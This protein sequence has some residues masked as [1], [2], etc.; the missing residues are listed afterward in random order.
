VIDGSIRSSDLLVRFGGDEFLVTTLETDLKECE[1]LISRINNLL[2]DWNRAH[3]FPDPGLS[4][5]IGCAIFEKGK[6]L[7]DVIREADAS[8][9]RNKAKKLEGVG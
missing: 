3:R 8:M 7:M 4:V 2:A 9:Y 1:N 6:D 5:S